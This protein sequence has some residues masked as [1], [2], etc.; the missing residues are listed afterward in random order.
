MAGDGGLVDSFEGVDFFITEHLVV[1][2][3]PEAYQKVEQWCIAQQIDIL[4]C[5]I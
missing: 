1:A 5:E 3:E 2:E 4:K